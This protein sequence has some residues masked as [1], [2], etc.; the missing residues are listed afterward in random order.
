MPRV[1]IKKLNHPK[2]IEELKEEQ[3]EENTRNVVKK[4]S[5]SLAAYLLSSFNNMNSTNVQQ[6]TVPSLKSE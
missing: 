6:S 4:K 1:R 3:H 5:V 2:T